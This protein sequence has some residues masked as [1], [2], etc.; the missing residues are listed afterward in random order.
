MIEIKNAVIDDVFLGFEDHGIFTMDVRMDYGG[1]VQNF[2]GY[3][4]GGVTGIEFIKEVL[5][6]V[7]VQSIKELLGKSVR[8]KTD[9]EYGQIIA[10]GHFLKDNWLNPKELFAK[11]GIKE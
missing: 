4:L 8:V 11:L 10:I 7:G 6:V 3:C 9:G 5:N 2:G 1:C